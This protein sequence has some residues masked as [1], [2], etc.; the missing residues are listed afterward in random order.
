MV[1]ETRPNI[2][3]E[4][5]L[6]EAYRV[7]VESAIEASRLILSMWNNPANKHFNPERA[8][9]IAAEKSEGTG[10]F[11]TIAD[12]LSEEHLIKRIRGNTLLAD[13]DIVTE[14]QDIAQTGSDFVWVND[15]IDGTLNFTNGLPDFA[16]SVG[17][18]HK[19]EPVMGVITLP[20]TEQLV[21]ARKGKGVFLTDFEG[22]IQ[23][24]LTERNKTRNLPLTKSLIGYDVTYDNRQSQFQGYV[25]KM[26]D[27]IG[28]PVSYYSCATAQAKVAIGLLG[29]YVM[30]GPKPFDIVAGACIIQEAGGVV[31]QMDGSPIDWS[32]PKNSYLAARNPDF[33]RQLLNLIK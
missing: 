15:P 26:A 13:H 8:L 14:E 27:H 21:V 12:L 24:D 30:A 17:L 1:I 5:I 23:A 29:G 20:A 33:H 2:E 16:I 28:A 3:T 32:K 11:A 10:N 9:T 31:S 6:D 19:G 25:S 7:G 22:H 18:L 4:V